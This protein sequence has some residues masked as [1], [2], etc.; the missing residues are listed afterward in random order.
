MKLEN[1]KNDLITLQ[2]AYVENE[3]II[4]ACLTQL[5]QNEDFDQNINSILKTLANQLDSDRAYYGRY[6]PDGSDYGISHEWTAA[7][8]S[9]LHEVRNPRFKKQFL[10]WR[11]QFRNNKLLEI[12]DILNSPFAEILREPGCQT[13]LCAPVTVNQ[14]LIGV[15]GLGFIRH[16]RRISEFDENMIRSVAQIISLAFQRDVKHRELD[17]AIRDRE[18]VFRN[19]SIPIMLFD[20]TGKLSR[21]NPAACVMANRNEG[22]ILMMPCNCSFCCQ[23]TTPAWC[24]V[25][26]AVRTGTA[27]EVELELHGREY[28]IKAEPVLE[29]DGTIRS[30]IENA[31]DITEI[32][33]SRRQ[34]ERA[35]LAE[36][37][38]NRPKSYFL[39]TMSHE[40]RTPLNAVIGFS[41]LLQ[42]EQL[43]RQEHDEY[44]RSIN[45]AGNALLSLINDVLD[46]SKLE[47][48]QM[49]IVLQPVDL[50]E[51]ARGLQAVFQYKIQEKKLR[52]ALD[53]PDDLPFL[54]LDH[55]RLRQ[56]LLNLLGN[57]VKL[58]TQGTISLVIRYLPDGNGRGCL[59]IDVRDTGIGLTPTDRKTIFE[60]FVQSDAVRGTHV[61]QGTGL[62]L[63]ISQR[64]VIRMGGVI[65]LESEVG[66]GS[67]FTVELPGIET[68]EGEKR[69]AT[70]HSPALYAALERKLRILLV[71]DVPLNLKV[72]SALLKKAGMESIQASSG[73]EALELLKRERPDLILT[74]I[75]MPGM[76]GT[77]LARKLREDQSLREIPIVAVTAD[78]EAKTNFSLGDFNGVLLKPV[79]V[80][81]I[82]ELLDQVR[83]AD[84]DPVTI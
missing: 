33:E 75:W 56:V 39:A 16:K 15:I 74:D 19:I 18:A 72:L 7:G 10:R 21:V 81:K 63:A 61:Y 51:M 17:A 1:E 9:S 68:A 37:A 12:P 14:I 54:K 29:E 13:L 57:A 69:T 79:T 82:Y 58:T 3:K 27:S 53:C 55:P 59:T 32:N 25:Q 28:V 64:L 49:M 84:S 36:K 44:V 26:Q 71:D 80:G 76:S 42:N 78:V 20:R 23:P 67:C 24:P 70:G 65:R 4:N 50:A 6:A 73:F 22:E 38:A 66:K 47:A 45:L 40:I 83:S 30:I 34:Q 35:V 62:G 8:V 5:V 31:I 52:F 77:E 48:D 41:E 43:L 60:P 46:L 11:E 2:K